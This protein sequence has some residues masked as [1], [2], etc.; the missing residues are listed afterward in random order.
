L[1]IF[2]L[3][4]VLEN[5]RVD[6]E[7]A[8][9]DESRFADSQEAVVGVCWYCGAELTDGG[10]TA[11]TCYAGND[12]ERRKSRGLSGVMEGKIVHMDH[13]PRVGCCFIVY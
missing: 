1:T 6:D 7:E 12:G 10:M 8:A 9:F 4:C 5:Q 3:A 2:L 11:T 13:A